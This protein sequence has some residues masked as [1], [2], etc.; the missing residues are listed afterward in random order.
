[1]NV[2]GKRFI[3]NQ[4]KENLSEFKEYT[5]VEYKFYLQHILQT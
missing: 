3:Y 2:H 5:R 1:M 4:G